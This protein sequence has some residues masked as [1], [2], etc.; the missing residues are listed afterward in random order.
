MSLRNF[1]GSV[2]EDD[3]SVLLQCASED[4]VCPLLCL[5]WTE[6]EVLGHI[7]GGVAQC[8]A[9]QGFFSVAGLKLEREQVRLYRVV[10]VEFEFHA[11][12][13]ALCRDGVDVRML[14]GGTGR[15]LNNVAEQRWLE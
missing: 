8:L 10:I 14:R 6:V 15:G 9:H 1:Q 11:E 4:F 7:Y 12:T 3:F 13:R 5:G 2:G